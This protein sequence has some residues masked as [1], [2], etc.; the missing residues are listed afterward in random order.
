MDLD[1]QIEK[2]IQ[3]ARKTFGIVDGQAMLLSELWDIYEPMSKQLPENEQDA[4][5]E[6]YMLLS[7]NDSSITDDLTPDK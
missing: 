5:R 7:C 4:L 3:E 2:D 6:K 1:A